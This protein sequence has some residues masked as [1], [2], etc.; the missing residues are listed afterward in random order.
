MLLVKDFGATG[1]PVTDESF[2]TNAELVNLVRY[3]IGEVSDTNPY[4]GE[5]FLSAK[6]FESFNVYRMDNWWTED[7]QKDYK[8]PIKDK[9]AYNIKQNIFVEKNWNRID[10]SKE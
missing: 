4:T 3:D 1:E 5:K 6:D 7:Y 9:V 2:V 10:T 8:Y